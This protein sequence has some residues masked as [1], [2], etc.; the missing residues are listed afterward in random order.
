ML[1][2][3]KGNAR[4]DETGHCVKRTRFH[5]HGLFLATEHFKARKVLKQTTSVLHKVRTAIPLCT[6]LSALQ[7]FLP[8][9][10]QVSAACGLNSILFQK[11][12]A[13]YVDSN[14]IIY[15]HS[16][17]SCWRKSVERFLIATFERA[18]LS[19][20]TG[21]SPLQ[22]FFFGKPRC[23]WAA[24]KAL[25]LAFSLLGNQHLL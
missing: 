23:P 19:V 12:S 20:L 11:R 10:T 24:Q 4:C 6:G 25:H 15:T 21:T 17:S 3:L 14:V 16:V 18:G 22:Y 8:A 1:G 2:C 5:F 7:C 13:V 9:C